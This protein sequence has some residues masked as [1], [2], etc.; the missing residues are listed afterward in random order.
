M[1][2]TMI[3]FSTDHGTHLGEEGC[4]QKTA[5]LLNGC[6]ERTPLIMR[7]PDQQ[8]AGKRIDAL[9]SHTDYMPTF[10]SLLG[11][12]GPKEMTG[13][14][15][16]PL[17]TGEAESIHDRV[18]SGYGNFAAVHDHQWHYFQNVKGK[19]KG[20]GPALYELKSDPKMTS[21]VFKDHPDVVEEMRSHLEKRFE[22]KLSG[23]MNVGS[24]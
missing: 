21:N 9:V 4:V 6:V 24:G 14:N 23:N 16:W 3:A 20:K 22:V 12:E 13:S 5:G 7:H 2:N 19:N 17:V 10:L 8:F 15:F 1:D 11:V 18:F